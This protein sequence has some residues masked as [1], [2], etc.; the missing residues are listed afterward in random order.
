VQPTRFQFAI[1]LQTARLLGIAVPPALLAV[2][3]ETIGIAAPQVP[4]KNGDRSTGRPPV[5]QKADAFVRRASSAEVGHKW[6]FTAR[7]VDIQ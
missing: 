5:P 3:D 7:H 6:T 1:N 2:A 4:L